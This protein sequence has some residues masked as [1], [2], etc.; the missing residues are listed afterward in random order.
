MRH[1]SIVNRS[2]AHIAKSINWKVSTRERVA[3]RS[4]WWA[5]SLRQCARSWSTRIGRQSNE[6]ENE[7]SRQSHTITL[8]PSDLPRLRTNG[9]PVG[10]RLSDIGA[11]QQ[12]GATTPQA[13]WTPA[14]RAV[15]GIRLPTRYV[16]TRVLKARVPLPTSL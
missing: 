2:S 15:P 11:V 10:A 9:P 13:G 12:S 1:S 5:S 14:E 4:W 8:T 16:E 7:G 6:N 3:A